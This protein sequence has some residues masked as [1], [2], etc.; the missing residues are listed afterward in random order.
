MARSCSVLETS[1]VCVVGRPAGRYSVGEK[2]PSTEEDSNDSTFV[3]LSGTGSMVPLFS[4]WRPMSM[5]KTINTPWSRSAVVSC[6]GIVQVRDGYAWRQQEGVNCYRV[7]TLAWYDLWSVL[8]RGLVTINLTRTIACIKVTLKF[9][10]DSLER[11]KHNLDRDSQVM[12]TCHI[13]VGQS[14]TGTD[15]L[16]YLT[17]SRMRGTRSLCMNSVVSPEHCS[18]N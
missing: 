5:A 18:I 7:M 12:A 15:A 11:S 10:E 9:H 1:C 17:P 4:Y 14:R 3:W 6:F 16:R 2:S 13:Q 8:M